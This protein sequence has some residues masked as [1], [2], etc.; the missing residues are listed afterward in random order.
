MQAFYRK[1][2]KISFDRQII[3]IILRIKLNKQ[4]TC[5]GLVFFSDLWYAFVEGYH[6][7]VQIY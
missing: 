2:V 3:S 6:I 5:G 1:N 7:K 4:W